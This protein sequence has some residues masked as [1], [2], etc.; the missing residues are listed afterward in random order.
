MNE[1]Y[2]QANM[3]RWNERVKI[4]A[5]SKFYD[6]EGFLKGKT[7]LLPIEIK[8]L[9][10]VSDK[11]MLHMQCHFGMDSLSWARKGAKVTAVDFAP[12]DYI[13][14]II[15]ETQMGIMYHFT[16]LMQILA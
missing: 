14:E 7:S 6:L 16:F 9:G 5:Q 8:E 15:V 3:Q 13:L 2:F 4:N 10:D 11:T 12:N 1:E